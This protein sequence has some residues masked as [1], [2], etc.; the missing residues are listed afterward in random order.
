VKFTVKD[1]VRAEV[2]EPFTPALLV[3]LAIGGAYDTVYGDSGAI[4]AGD[5][6]LA[7]ALN[8]SDRLPGVK[9]AMMVTVILNEA[10]EPAIADFVN[11][12]P[13]YVTTTSLALTPVTF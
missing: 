3:T 1:T 5:T 2:V 12:P 6:A 4:A 7:L 9:G 8:D 13:G 10:P 11:E